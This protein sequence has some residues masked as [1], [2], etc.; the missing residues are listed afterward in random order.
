LPTDS[1]MG[2]YAPKKK[3]RCFHR[4]LILLKSKNIY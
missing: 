1:S 2:I 3:G 4:P